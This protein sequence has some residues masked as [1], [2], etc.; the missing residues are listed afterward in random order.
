M[1]TFEQWETLHG[2]DAMIYAAESGKDREL[3]FNRERYLEDCYERHLH[4]LA[5]N[6]L[7]DKVRGKFLEMSSEVAGLVIKLDQSGSGIVQ[8]HA[9]AIQNGQDY[10]VANLIIKALLEEFSNRYGSD[11]KHKN[12]MRLI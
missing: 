9:E 11:N 8:L 7:K 12:L 10:K 4:Y 3:C 5:L 1:I 6:D 2:D